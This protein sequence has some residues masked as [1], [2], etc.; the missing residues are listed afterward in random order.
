[1]VPKSSAVGAGVGGA[2][3]G[4]IV[5]VLAV[6]LY[7]RIRAQR[8][9]QKYND[10]TDAT[11]HDL[12]SRDPPHDLQPGSHTNDSPLDPHRIPLVP[13]RL[14]NFSG[15]GLEHRIQPFPL[16]NDSPN[17]STSALNR[18][19][20]SNTQADSGIPSSSAVQPPPHVYVV[21]HDAGRA[22]V[23]V[24]TAQGTEVVELPPQYMD[25]SSSSDVSRNPSER[26]AESN[27]S[28]SHNA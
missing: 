23:T 28:K 4:V 17:A 9:S 11:Y 24:Y 26:Q 21:H 7:E 22:P 20:S 27:S 2:F 5:A 10:T 15:R 6:I 16:T 1:M 14:F 25:G 12:V 18:M 13:N 19:A 3:A 8:R